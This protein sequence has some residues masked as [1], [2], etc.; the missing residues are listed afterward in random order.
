[1]IW[2]W[3]YAR[4]E[5]DGNSIDEIISIFEEKPVIELNGLKT[6]EENNRFFFELEKRKDQP[7]ELAIFYKNHL[8]RDGSASNLP[9]EGLVNGIKEMKGEKVLDVMRSFLG[10]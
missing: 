4:I 3:I 1:M 10:R 2:Y 8:V 7:L 5:S 9:I 6:K